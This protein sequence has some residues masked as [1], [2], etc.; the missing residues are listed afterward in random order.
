MWD[1]LFQLEDFLEKV[2]L[3]AGFSGEGEITGRAVFRAFLEQFALYDT[4]MVATC[5]YIEFANNFVWASSHK[6]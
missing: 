1:K 3:E 4:M 2:K 5:H 6:T